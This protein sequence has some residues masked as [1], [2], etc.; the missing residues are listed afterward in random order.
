ML[1]WDHPVNDYKNVTIVEFIAFLAKNYVSNIY[2]AG[3]FVICV[4][5]GRKTMIQHLRP[6]GKA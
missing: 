1:N 3:A 2:D 6:V 4:R 5:I